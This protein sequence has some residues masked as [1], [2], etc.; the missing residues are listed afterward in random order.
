[1]IE[2]RLQTGDKGP[3]FTVCGTAGYILSEKDAERESQEFWESC[4]EEGE[5]LADFNRQN[6]SRYRSTERAARFLRSY[7]GAYS[8]L[9]VVYPSDVDTDDKVFVAHSCGQI[10]SEL[11]R[12][13]PDFDWTFPHHL[14]DLHAGCEHQDAR[15]ET[16]KTHPDAVCPDCGYRL[17]SGWTYR[18]LPQSILDLF[19]PETKGG[20]S[21]P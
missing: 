3:R 9:D 7:E 8:G 20:T 4:L 12:F 11:Q 15:G 2:L 6:N 18:P 21:S 14:N 13:F 16:Y 10:R 19:N 17:G 5:N 1:V